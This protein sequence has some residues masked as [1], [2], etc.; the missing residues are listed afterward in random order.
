LSGNYWKQKYYIVVLN[1]KLFR[2]N[3]SDQDQYYRLI[4]S[5]YGTKILEQAKVQLNE[6]EYYTYVRDG[7]PKVHSFE[8]EMVKKY[9]YSR[10]HV[11]S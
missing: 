7:I 6:G 8:S 5:A 11:D 3:C 10:H 4:G 1:G 2:Q 9:A